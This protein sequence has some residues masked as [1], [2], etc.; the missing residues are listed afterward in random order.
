M[1]FS[2]I[3][4]NYNG[5]SFLEETIRSV[6]QQRQDGID[7]EFIVVD[8]ESSDGSH[9]ILEKYRDEIDTLIIE[10]DSGPANAI[11]KGLSVATGDIIAWLNADDLYYSG[12]LKRVQET[13]ER[14]P[15]AAFCFGACTIVNE[16]GKESRSMIT[17]FKELFYPLS[18]RFAFQCINYLSQPAVFFRRQSF[19]KAGLLREDMVGA[20]D[21]EFFLRLWHSGKSCQIKG[22]PVSAFRWHEQ[23]ISG[24]NFDVQFK[25]EYEAACE[26][27]GKLSMQGLTHFFVRWG[28]V[29]IYSLMALIR[30]KRR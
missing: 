24:Q 2:V 4:P 25:E 27:A 11:N 22:A 5:A 29:G 23:S 15:N 28:I 26:D 7:L 1:R 14:W 20:W 8:G 16:Q 10:K 19:V 6:L 21:Y 9:A 17:T 18:S 30:N 3:T 13:I 12:A